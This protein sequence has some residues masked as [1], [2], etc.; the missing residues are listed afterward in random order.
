MFLAQATTG[1]EGG[2][3][4]LEQANTWM[5]A[6]G[7]WVIEYAPRIAGVILLLIAAWIAAGWVGR[8]VTRSIVRVKVETTLA[9]FFGSLS[10]WALLIMA[11]IACLGVFGVETTSFA[12]VIGAGTLAIGLAFQ[13]SLSNLAAG[14][15]LLIF[16][17][18]KIGD[19]VNVAGQLGKVGEIDLFTTK[20][21]TFDN[22][23]IILPNG[24]VFGATI[25]N[26]THHPTRRVDAPVGVSYSADIDRTRGILDAA[27]RQVAGILDD[28]APAVVL[29][30][31]GQ[32]SVDWAVRDWTKSDT[33]WPVREA[34][35]R[36]IK[37]SLDQAGIAIPF[38]QMDVHVDGALGKPSE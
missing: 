1:P 8:A 7:N 21:S 2:Q 27:A 33:Y 36:S 6:I 17:P 25:E 32:S 22:R 26:I 28:P 10:K 18:F 14:V 16:R 9:H 23:L 19:V 3:S 37:Y 34:L 31:L 24:S 35:I 5:A 15:M 20:L 4:A 11:L 38:P 29:T 12:A 30:G 13:G